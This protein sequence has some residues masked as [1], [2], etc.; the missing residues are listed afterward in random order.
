MGGDGLTALIPRAIVEC[1]N[2]DRPPRPREYE[3][4]AERFWRD[5]S[6]GGEV[7]KWL[8]AIGAGQRQVCLRAAHAALAGDWS[9]GA[10]AARLR[11]LER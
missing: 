3:G 1:I 8:P 10:L 9:G 2:E 6:V 7:P 5:V 4:V 11:Q